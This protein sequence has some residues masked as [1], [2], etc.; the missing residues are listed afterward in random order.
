MKIGSLTGLA[1]LLITPNVLAGSN[2]TAV[3]DPSAIP[4]ISTTP[5][6]C[7][8]G[9]T[10]TGGTCLTKD[11]KE[12]VVEA[13][14]ELKD[15]HDSKAKL[16][17]PQPIVIIRDWQNSV[18][19]NG[20][21]KKPIPAKLTIGQHVD[22]DLEI[23]LPIQLY[24]R[25]APPKPWFRFRIRAQLGV[26]VPEVVQDMSRSGGSFVDGGIG[27]DFFHIPGIE[28]N[29][30]VYTGIRSAGGGLGL[31]LTKNFGVY[32]GYSFVYDGLKSSS[33]VAGYFAFN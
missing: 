5:P 12:K 24:Y 11:Q 29:L 1:I 31:D 16:D 2:I 8:Q 27:W 18:Y 13:L 30:A 21:A 10:D 28:L 20:G 19:I 7:P 22:R 33:L 26:L 32:A 23:Q 14:K 6:I 25:K 3:I 9:V 17:F 4:T 15:I